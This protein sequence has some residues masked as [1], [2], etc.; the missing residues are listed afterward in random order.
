MSPDFPGRYDP[1]TLLAGASEGIG[2]CLARRIATQ[3][4]N[5]VLID[6]RADQL[7]ALKHELE[8]THPA[9][10]IRSLAGD[11]TDSSTLQAIKDLAQDIE[12]GFLG[13]I[14]GSSSSHPD[15]LDAEFETPGNE[16]PPLDSSRIRRDLDF[17][18]AF[19]LLDGVRDYIERIRAYD[20]CSH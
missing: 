4:V 14:A 12:V 13:Y 3:G 16:H 5:L 19:T 18:P 1:W 8:A 10:E 20:D 2:A 11:L 6:F 15:F 7:E 17:S 9:C